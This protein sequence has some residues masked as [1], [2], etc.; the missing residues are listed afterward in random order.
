MIVLDLAC[1]AGHRFEGW[2]ASAEAFEDQHARGLVSCPEC[3]SSAV[4]RRP[5]APY[6]QTPRQTPRAPQAEQAAPPA[7]PAPAASERALTAAD[8]QSM[9]KALLRQ[10]ARNTENVGDKFAEE[11]RR[12]HHGEAESRDIRGRAT[13][14]ELESLLDEGIS[15]LPV[16]PEDDPVH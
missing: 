7:K 11:A 10:A 1:D 12:I 14:D 5:S 3:G 6:V 13:R 16:P 15:V 8:A 4:T 9:L 2:F